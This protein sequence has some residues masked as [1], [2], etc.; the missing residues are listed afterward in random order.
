[1]IK[2]VKHICIQHKRFLAL[3]ILFIFAI[4][5]S[6]KWRTIYLQNRLPISGYK[7][8]E[9]I[10]LEKKDISD[11]FTRIL[12]INK[13][14]SFTI[15]IIEELFQI[16]N[17]ALDRLII[18]HTDNFDKIPAPQ[19]NGIFFINEFNKKL[20]M[21]KLR[22]KEQE[23]NW[24]LFYE[25][26]FLKQKILL[27]SVNK[28]E[29]IQ[30]RSMPKRGDFRKI[31][32]ALEKVMSECRPGIYY[33]SQHLISSCACYRE[34]EFLENILLDSGNKLRLIVIG[35]FSD[36]DIENFQ[37]E[38]NYRIIVEKSGVNISD[39]VHDWNVDTNRWDFNFIVIK[40][41]KRIYIFPLID[42][43]DYQRWLR[44][45]ENSLHTI[46]EEYRNN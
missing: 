26:G 39:L 6:Q 18:F 41:E 13:L 27:K 15:S 20:L 44:F 5:I 42:S 45:K 25:R 28:K 23:I 14:N 24:V 10:S 31:S 1:M 17:E 40:T 11:Y 46:I 12:I 19:K 34:F 2:E 37:K 35:E 43:V 36:L 9:S 4:M 30:S 29:I 16:H 3:G 38:K 22:I 7:T 21:N 32:L 33:F 8:T